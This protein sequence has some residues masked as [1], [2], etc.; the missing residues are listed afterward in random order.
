MHR[1]TFRMAAA[2]LLASA[3]PALAQ[4]PPADFTADLMAWV[5]TEGAKM[6][7]APILSPPSLLMAPLNR[8]AGLTG[9]VVH[10]LRALAAVRYAEVG[11]SDSEIQAIIGHTTPGMAT[12]Y[13]RDADQKLRATA[14]VTRL[15]AH[16]DARNANASATQTAKP[17]ESGIAK[18]KPK[19]P[20]TV[21]KPSTAKPLRGAGDEIRTRDPEIGNLITATAIGFL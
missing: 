1:D 3:A 13:R 17:Q 19:T 4:L 16:G 15:D 7:A 8:P 2:V 14:A 12:H 9:V 11:C 10:G 20:A 21:Q 5:A 6:E 18:P